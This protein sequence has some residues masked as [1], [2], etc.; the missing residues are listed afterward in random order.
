M[1]R[2][3]YLKNKM[4]EGLIEE[5]MLVKMTEL[6]QEHNGLT[7]DG[8]FGPNTAASFTIDP[9]TNLNPFSIGV[10]M[11]AIED[12]GKGEEGGNNSGP[13]VE[14]ILGK[15][16]DG[17]DDNDGAWCAAAVSHWIERAALQEG[18]DLKFSLSF[19]A[20]ALFRNIKN[21]GESVEEPQ[22][23]DIVCW[24]RGD[25]GSWQGHIGVVERFDNGILHTIEGNKGRFPSKVR[26]F[27]YDLSKESRLEGFAR[28]TDACYES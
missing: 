18:V 9:P 24:D 15:V 7:V 28:F 5:W 26:R 27:R 11:A 2:E 10:L 21:V 6:W 8:Y 25:V 14:G 1:T 17:D 3:E 23:G 4:D 13:Y 16:F 20:K 22:A 12:L 19:G